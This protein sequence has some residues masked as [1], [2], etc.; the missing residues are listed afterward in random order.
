MYVSLII[1]YNVCDDAK[2]KTFT[3]NFDRL[4]IKRVR[5]VCGKFSCADLL[6]RT[7]SSHWEMNELKSLVT[8]P[9]PAYKILLISNEFTKF[10]KEK[11]N[12]IIWY[13]M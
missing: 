12:D 9:T 11:E 3:C 4:Q 6:V 5:I 10:Q 2:K 7:Y 1:N 8:A 13:E